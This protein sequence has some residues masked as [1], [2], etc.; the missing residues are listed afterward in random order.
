MKNKTLLQLLIVTLLLC[1][2]EDCPADDTIVLQL[3]WR[4]QFQ[5]AGYYAAIE[6]GFYREE[7]LQV[8]LREN[9]PGLDV[10]E[11]VMNGN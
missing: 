3:K 9:N 8:E 7:G 10:I 11:E 2:F 6:K 5:F 1:S 4:H